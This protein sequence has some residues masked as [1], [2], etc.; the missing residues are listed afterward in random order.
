MRK[1]RSETVALWTKNLFI[2]MGVI[3]ALL[4]AITVRE[5]VQELHQSRLSSECRFDINGD[6]TAVGDQINITTA[7][8]VV[9]AIRNDDTRVADLGKIL[10]VQIEDYSSQ[11]KIRARAAEV[12]SRR[13]R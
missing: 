6:V 2:G 1:P 7:R 13:N 12:C 4:T 3:A 9:A 5:L 10:E 8:V 11:A